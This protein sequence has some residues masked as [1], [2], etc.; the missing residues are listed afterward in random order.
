MSRYSCKNCGASIDGDDAT[1][2][3]NY[4]LRKENEAFYEQ[5]DRLLAANDAFVHFLENLSVY[6]AL[7]PF[8]LRMELEELAR[9]F[10]A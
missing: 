5:R 1:L 8:S 6:K 3:E 2:V 4:E 9:V 7:L 10:G